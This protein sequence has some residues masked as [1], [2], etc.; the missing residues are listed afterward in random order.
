[1]KKQYDERLDEMEARLSERN[2][3]D[4]E[5]DKPRVAAIDPSIERRLKQLQ[6][7]VQQ[8]ADKCNELEKVRTRVIQCQRQCHLVHRGFIQ[9][10]N[11]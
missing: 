7:R 9:H 10:Y 5:R 6:E 4:A 3:V 2:S 11:R 8:T 1:M